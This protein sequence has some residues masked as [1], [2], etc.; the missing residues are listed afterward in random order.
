MKSDPIQIKPANR[1]K[2]HARL[3]VPSGETIPAAK[4][5]AALRSPDPSLRKEALF[6]KA[7]KG[8]KK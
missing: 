4:L 6:A 7:A 2:L 5:A 1:G 3:K 8:W